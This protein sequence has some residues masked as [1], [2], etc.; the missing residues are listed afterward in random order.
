[1]PWADML[2]PYRAF[3]VM[4]MEVVNPLPA[5][6]S[7]EPNVLSDRLLRGNDGLNFQNNSKNSERSEAPY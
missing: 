6:N 4:L 3:N 7:E 2:R 1:M 5:Q